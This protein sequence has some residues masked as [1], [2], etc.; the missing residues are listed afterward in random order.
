M[1]TRFVAID[2]KGTFFASQA[3]V[4]ALRARGGGAIVNIGS[5]WASQAVAATPSSAYSAAKAGVHALTKN[6]AMEL[7]PLQIRVN[8]LAPAVV[9]TP[10]YRAFVPEADI[11][12]VLAS[13]DAFHPLGRVGTTADVVGAV[14]FFAGEGA[15]WITG[16][17]L[18][19]DGG[20]M[21]GRV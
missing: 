18:P 12:K 5:M 2:D 17:V 13:F 14:L 10:V 6:L 20:V 9:D 4:P 19:V 21:A 3:A 7:A 11:P 15:R 8:T 16:T 1:F